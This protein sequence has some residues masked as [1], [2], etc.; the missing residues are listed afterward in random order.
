MASINFRAAA[1]RIGF[2]REIYNFTEPQFEEDAIIYVAKENNQ[3]K[4]LRFHFSGQIL[5]HKALALK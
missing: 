2:E 4:F 1:I 5:Y 3:S